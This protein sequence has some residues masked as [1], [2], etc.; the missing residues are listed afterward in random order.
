MVSVIIITYNRL[1]DLIDLINN[2]QEQTFSD[3][4][5]IVVDNDSQD[6][7]AQVIPNKFPNIHFVANPFNAG[8]PG[9]RNIGIRQATGE[10]LVFI[11][12]DAEI[13]PEFLQ[14]VITMFKKFPDVGILTFKVLNYYT[15]EIDWGSWIY[16]S[17][18]QN[19]TSPIAVQ[20]FTGGAWAM[21]KSV[22]DKIGLMWDD[23]F[24]M[25]EEKEYSLR[26]LN[27]GFQIL[28]TPQIKVYHKISPQNR[29]Q[30]DER[31]FYYGI[32]NEIWIYL[33]NVPWKFTIPHLLFVGFAGGLYALRKGFFKQYLKGVGEGVAHSGKALKLRKPIKDE[34]YRK[35]LK[36]LN[37]K[38]DPIGRRI[39]RF[40][41]GGD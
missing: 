18:L 10:Y 35:Y 32:R 23:L 13:D 6:E 2:L 30:V 8:V 41:K 37:K 34:T 21:R 5:I 15:K 14:Q 1:K 28:F 20:S 40:V 11:D 3:F 12:N 24:F 26:A 29:Y 38:K 4:E 36:L 19:I 27:A 17:E 22:V 16:N 9:G 25:H 39:L 7:T 33:K 31:F